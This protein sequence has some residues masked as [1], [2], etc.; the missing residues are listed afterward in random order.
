MKGCCVCSFLEYYA[1]KPGWKEYSG[2]NV[3]VLGRS[4]RDAQKSLA[5]M[6]FSPCQHSSRLRYEG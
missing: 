3:R 4:L 5:S 1:C 2:L 6:L